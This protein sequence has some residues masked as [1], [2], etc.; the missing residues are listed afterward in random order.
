ML[1]FRINEPYLLKP[2][3][4]NFKPESMKKGLHPEYNEITVKMNDG[5]EIVTRSTMKTKDG[6]F[7]PDIDSTNHP[8]Y[9]GSQKMITADGR[10]D[11]FKKRYAKFKK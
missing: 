8:F 11:K 10:V 7:K 6:V 5:T 3:R 4:K 9:R 2:K 1:S